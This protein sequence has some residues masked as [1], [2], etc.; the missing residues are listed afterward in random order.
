[1]NN[2]IIEQ[3][4]ATFVKKQGDLSND[5]F[6]FVKIE[7]EKACD[8]N[9][10]DFGSAHTESPC[11]DFGMNLCVSFY[12]RGTTKETITEDTKALIKLVRW[13]DKVF[14][15]TDCKYINGIWS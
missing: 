9:K 10:W 11:S 12:E 3:H 5:A 1:M 6:T 4:K 13:C 2:F 14:K 7:I 8:A 15:F